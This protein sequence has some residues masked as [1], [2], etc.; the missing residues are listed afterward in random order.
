MEDLSTVENASAGFLAA[1]FSSLT[2]CPTE[3]IK[4]RLQAMK[5]VQ[6]QKS[7]AGEKIASLYLFIY[8]F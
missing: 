8:L 3:L 1:F 2:L 6:A 4:C 7:A 5:E